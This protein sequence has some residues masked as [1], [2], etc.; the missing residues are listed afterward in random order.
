MIK[1]KK[2]QHSSLLRT[3][4]H[5]ISPKRLLILLLFPFMLWGMLFS[6]QMTSRVHAA[7]GVDSVFGIPTWHK[8]LESAGDAP[9]GVCTPRIR[10]DTP[11]ESVN[12]VLPIGLA[13]IE[14]GVTLGAVVAMVMVMWGSFNFLTTMGDTNK[15]ASARRTVQNSLIGLVILI[16]ATRVVSFVANAL[17]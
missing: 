14:I 4:L 2:L 6:P 9:G 7:C 17:T 10:G 5:C 13:V 3:G 12:L 8:Y 1:N 16:I 15:A 11:E